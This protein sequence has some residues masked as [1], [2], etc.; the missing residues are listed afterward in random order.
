MEDCCLNPNYAFQEPGSKLC[1][2]CRLGGAWGWGKVGRTAA[3]RPRSGLSFSGI[4]KDVSKVL[5]MTIALDFSAFV[6]L[7]FGTR[8]LLLGWGLTYALQGVL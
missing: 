4:P 2:A 8:K 3:G 6:L 7:T 5:I 1:Q